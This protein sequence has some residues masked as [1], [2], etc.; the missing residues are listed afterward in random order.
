MFANFCINANARITS[1]IKMKP[2]CGRPKM[3]GAIDEGLA[4]FFINSDFI[5]SLSISF[6]NGFCCAYLKRKIRLWMIS[7]KIA[8]SDESPLRLEG[9]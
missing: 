2:V 5:T 4:F 1:S 6:T 9:F 3:R 8:I 7:I